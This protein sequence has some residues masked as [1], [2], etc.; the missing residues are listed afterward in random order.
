MKFFED[1][2]AQ[3]SADLAYGGQ[4]KD[5]AGLAKSPPSNEDASIG[6]DWTPGED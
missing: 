3:T 1:F 5:C 2:D 4:D 6:G